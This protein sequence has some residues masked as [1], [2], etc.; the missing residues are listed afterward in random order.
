[1]HRTTTNPVRNPTN[2]TATIISIVDR[3]RERYVIFVVL[4]VG[5]LT[6]RSRVR[7]LS[8]FPPGVRWKN[9]E[10][11]LLCDCD[12]RN[13][14]AAPQLPQPKYQPLLATSLIVARSTLGPSIDNNN[15]PGRRRRSVHSRP[16]K[17]ANGIFPPIFSHTHVVQRTDER[18]F[19]SSWFRHVYVGG[20]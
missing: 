20:Q 15:Q 13:P 7:V 3:P 19:V 17:Q 16:S 2:V 14:C 11:C 9:E 8:W 5:M 10:L 18:L 12:C 6:T 4:L 1:M